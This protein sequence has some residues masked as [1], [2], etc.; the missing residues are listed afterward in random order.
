[1]LEYPEEDNSVKALIHGVAK[2]GIF[3]IHVLNV[4]ISSKQVEFL[5]CY[6]EYGVFV[7]EYGQRTRSV[8]PTWSHLPFSFGNMII[9]Y[10]LLMI[11]F[12]RKQFNT[13]N[14]NN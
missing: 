6:N 11:T 2:H 4:S 13:T 12:L 9:I 1:M 8:D 5:L 3:P 7:N 10:I 14:K